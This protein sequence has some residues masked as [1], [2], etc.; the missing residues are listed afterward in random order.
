MNELRN[1]ILS[2]QNNNENKRI[3]IDDTNE[4]IINCLN[5]L[6]YNS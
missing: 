3:E 4:E 6:F 1:T 5:K 2:N